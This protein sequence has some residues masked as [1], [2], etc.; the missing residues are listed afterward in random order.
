MQQIFFVHSK[1]S[2]VA[3]LM[4]VP[5]GF[6]LDVASAYQAPGSR[7]VPSWVYGYSGA[8]SRQNLFY[9]AD[10]C[11]A[12][13]AGCFGIVLNPLT[14]TQRHITDS[15]ETGDVVEGNVDPISCMARCTSDKTIFA[16]GEC[17]MRPRI[18]VWSSTTMK[19]ISE[20]HG[21]FRTRV[22][23]VCFNPSGRLIA[24]LGYTGS[25]GGR[26]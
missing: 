3:D 26:M 25:G 13:P 2:A 1:G 5:N 10:G 24:A 17:A 23:S 14:R 15:A 21:Y 12:F 6:K 7:L 18:V 22:V 19:A 11:I 4:E 20:L 8:S 9:T 16:T